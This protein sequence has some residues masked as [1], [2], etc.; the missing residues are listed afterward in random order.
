MHST[1]QIEDVRS[2]IEKL[3]LE[4]PSDKTESERRMYLAGVIDTMED[5]GYIPKEMHLPLYSEFVENIF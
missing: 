3:M 5:V 1:I 4:L 2:T